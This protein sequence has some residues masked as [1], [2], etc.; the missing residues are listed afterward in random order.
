MKHPKMNL[1][2]ALLLSSLFLN[3]LNSDPTLGNCE[4]FPANNIWNTPV[5]T[6]P[7]H[8]LSES[9]VRSIGAQK[10][11]KADFGSGL[12][13]GMP[14]GI[15]FI[16]T[17]SANPVPVSFE[18]TEESEP[19]P[20]PIPHNAPIEGGETS[21]GDRHV[22]VVEQKT[23]KLYEL[24]SARKKGKSWTAISGAVF[25]LKSNQL[26]PANWTS[27]D[28]AGLP[29]LPGLVRYEEIASGEIKHAI[30]FTAKKTQKAYLWP[31]RHYASKITD[32]N[33]PPMGTRFRLKAS[34]N[35]DGFSKE[36]QVILR[37]LKKYGM[38]LA[39]NGSDWFLSGAPNE[40]WN[41]DQLHKLGK[42]LGDQFEAVDSESLMLSADSGE[43]KQN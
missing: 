7:L 42:V 10:K 3:P 17:S 41:N 36:N 6:L 34:F 33:V 38:I 40:K 22:L 9:Y 39:D 32:K 14:I 43:T 31:A 29:I 8:P 2:G 13:E 18:Y 20:Y 27:A 37:A 21:D 24:Y 19:G 28:A 35:I 4:V 30:R 26:R 15:P 5:D 16:L 25:D 11:L 1:L 23:C 12:W